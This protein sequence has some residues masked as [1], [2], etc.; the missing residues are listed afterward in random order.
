MKFEAKWCGP[1]KMIDNWITINMPDLDV[2]KID[3]DVDNNN[4]LAASFGIRSIPAM[5]IYQPDDKG[6]EERTILSTVKEIQEYLTE[7]YEVLLR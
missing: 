1:C 4:E 5:I 7:N 3:I 6:T 2:E